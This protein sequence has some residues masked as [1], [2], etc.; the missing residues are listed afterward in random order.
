MGDFNVEVGDKNE[1]KNCRLLWT[2]EKR[3]DKIL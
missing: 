1:W 3:S 2:Q